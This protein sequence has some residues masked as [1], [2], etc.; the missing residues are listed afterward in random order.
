MASDEFCMALDLEKKFPVL[1]RST[2]DYNNLEAM[3]D[4]FMIK[5]RTFQKQ[6]AS[7]YFIRLLHL[8]P[9]VLERAKSRW[10]SLP[11][12][13]EYVAKALDVPND[14]VCY[15]IGT[16][17]MDMA[18]KPNVLKDLSEESSVVLPPTPE[19][20]RTEKPV[21]SLEDESGRVRLIGNQLDKEM[22][23]TGM[24][25]GVLGREEPVSGAFEVIEVCYPGMPKQMPLPTNHDQK[26]V[27][28]VSGLNI[29]SNAQSDLKVQMMLEYL[30]GELGSS[31]D[32]T[33]ASSITRVII[34]G[35][36]L[37]PAVPKIEKGKKKQ[38]GYDATSFDS[39][40]LKHLDAA[41]G[42]LCM[43]T[44]IDLMPGRQDPVAMHLPQQPL[45]RF[46]FDTCKQYSSFHTVT[47]PHW[48]Q[49]DGVKFL[50]TSGQN[51]D[52]I[53]KYLDDVDRL[54]MIEESL[55]WRHIAPSAPDTL[56]CHPFQNHDPFL[57]DECPHVYFIGNQQQ[58]ETNVVKGE[59]GQS[60]RVV[61]VP[62]FAET[63]TIVLV[64]VST[65]E[66]LSLSF[67]DDFIGS[68]SDRID[69]MDES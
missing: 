68:P 20:Y 27:A 11:E 42:E 41:L 39:Q 26:F 25:V 8:R 31:M 40:P 13:P 35:N 18:L 61:L 60:V 23:I 4:K 56:W 43:T 12:K 47:N 24:V 16:I 30:S 2:S 9:I 59:D 5:D 34:A 54:K 7:I 37:A 15:I 19:K 14:E 63:G 65:L 21:I 50:G 44:D 66:C 28:V 49:I 45:R 36:S 64:N 3:N 33:N 29:G 46:L 55:F 32:Q 17:Y 51:L 69:A 38:Y 6:Y 58:F 48:C 22:L 62:S 52:D 10:A 1:D 67:S 53:Y 57:L